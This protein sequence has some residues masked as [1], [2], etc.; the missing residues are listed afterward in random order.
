MSR[1]NS[2]A[3][4]QFC[5]ETGET[6][7]R[8]KVSYVNMAPQGNVW[9]AVAKASE[10]ATNV[11]AFQTKVVIQ[12]NKMRN[13]LGSVDIYMYSSQFFCLFF[14]WKSTKDPQTCSL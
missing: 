4:V 13:A 3:L 1:W 8:I 10:T 14:C 12:K 6:V 9:M 5:W 11:N 2:R 7:A